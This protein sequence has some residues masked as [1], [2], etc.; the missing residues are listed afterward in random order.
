MAK[1][2]T[3]LFAAVDKSGELAGQERKPF[4]KIS[5][6]GKKVVLFQTTVKA[7]DAIK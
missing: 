2:T 4:L 1:C 5:L 7:C 6:F 3:E